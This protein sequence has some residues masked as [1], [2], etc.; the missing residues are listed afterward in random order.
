MLVGTQVADDPSHHEEISAPWD[1]LITP[2]ERRAYGHRKHYLLTPSIT[3][4]E[5][6]F[7]SLVRIRGLTPEGKLVFSIPLRQGSKS[8]YWNAPPCHRKIPA[9]LPGALDL[10]IDAGQNH[11]VVLLDISL[12][13]R[14]LPSHKATALLRA[15]AARHIPAST[16]AIKHLGN[17]LRQLLEQAHRNPDMLR[18][19]FQL[20]TLEED[21]LLRL[22]SL[23]NI[24]AEPAKRAQ[25]SIRQQGF[26]RALELIRGS[27]CSTLSISQLYDASCVSRRTL[28][29]AFRENFDMAPMDYIRLHRF[30][31]VRR[32]LLIA[33][34]SRATVSAIA[35][36]SG[37]Y[38]LGRFAAN[39]KRIFHELPSQTLAAAPLKTDAMSNLT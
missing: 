30:H 14:V 39:Y 8:S 11:L 19:P 16:T 21:L 10:R 2:L 18:H 23:L 34:N 6:N 28:E 15:A 13:Q 33:H 22:A 32:A 29:Y 20:Q 36:K 25:A 4:Y 7:D 26:R 35:G 38:E 1:I 37:F 9:S 12:L 27:D 5:E 3:I 17:W 31:A 24:S